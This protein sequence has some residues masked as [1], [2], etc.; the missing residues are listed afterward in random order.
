MKTSGHPQVFLTSSLFILLVSFLTGCGTQEEL[1]LQKEIDSISHHYI[2]DSR[3]GIC[4]ISFRK[5]NESKVVISGETTE[6]LVRTDII[7]SL[8]KHHIN[9]IDSILTL[10]DTSV[11][12]LC[13]GLVTLS[14]INLRKLPAHSSELVSQ[15]IMGTP[16]MILK[17]SDSWL[18]IQTPDKY[19]S[20]TESSSIKRLNTEEIKSWK[21]SERIIYTESTGWIYSK[22]E[23]DAVIS[24]IVAGSILQKVSDEKGF[25][26]VMTPDGRKGFLSNRTVQDFDKWRSA[27]VPDS[28]GIIRRASSY[29]GIPYLW[30]GTSP[31]GA[32]CSGFTQSVF[33][34]NGVIL[35]R[36]ASLQALHGVPI[37]ISSG[38]DKLRTGDLLF[39]GSVKN[40]KPR[41]TH[42]AIYLYDKEYINASG[43]VVVNS[44]DS[45]RKNF[46]ERIKGL[47][48]TKRVIGVKDDPGI[49]S[50]KDHSWY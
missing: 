1:N 11:N 20:W 39:F 41:V 7:K 26:Q 30:G 46:G 31:K 13:H 2:P 21:G 25:V 40:G 28:L 49:V 47:L 50:V 37:D 23:E 4:N 15:A 17:E 3:I 8:D 33:F 24:D 29:T 10:P 35:Q 27:V 36:D 34:L 44:L 12:K 38:F 9:Y 42:V 6:P 19:I 43:R 22:P 32:D 5:I 14:V 45:T 16:V 18:L 48:M